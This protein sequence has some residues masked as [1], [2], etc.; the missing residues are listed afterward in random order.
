MTILHLKSDQETNL[1][2]ILTSR[3]VTCRLCGSNTV[4]PEIALNA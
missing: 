4:P 3:E 1:M 2:T